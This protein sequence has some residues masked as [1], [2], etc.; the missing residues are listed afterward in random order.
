MHSATGVVEHD[1]STV[2]RHIGVTSAAHLDTCARRHNATFTV[3]PIDVDPTGRCSHIDG[4]RALDRNPT[5]RRQ[6]RHGAGPTTDVDTTR[7][8]SDHQVSAFGNEDPDLG[9]PAVDR[10]PSAVNGL[11]PSAR[12]HLGPTRF[13]D[14]LDRSAAGT[15]SYDGNLDGCW[16]CRGPTVLPS[17]DGRQVV[18]RHSKIGALQRPDLR[19]SPVLCGIVRTQCTIQHIFRVGVSRGVR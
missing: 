19:D 13:G 16:P 5:R 2:D 7:R 4:S 17:P 14:D 8:R 12:P 9:A 6:G 10:W 3:D 18:T 11:Q 1:A 15:D